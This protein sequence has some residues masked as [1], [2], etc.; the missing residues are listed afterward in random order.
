MSYKHLDMKDKIN[1]IMMISHHSGVIKD[2]TN[3]TYKRFVVTFQNTSRDDD[4]FLPALED[5][6]DPHPDSEIHIDIIEQ[7]LLTLHKQQQDE[8]QHDQQS[9][10]QKQQLGP[11]QLQPPTAVILPEPMTIPDKIQKQIKREESVSNPNF[12]GQSMYDVSPN[13]KLRNPAIIDKLI[14]YN[15]KTRTYWAKNFGTDR[16]MLSI[17]FHF[18][19][20]NLDNCENS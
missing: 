17:P 14:S 19:T 15:P 3:Y 20:A 12:K 9:Q 5:L 1:P 11:S 6:L 2:L 10:N 4:F 8:Q 7:Y 13:Y 18:L 16:Q